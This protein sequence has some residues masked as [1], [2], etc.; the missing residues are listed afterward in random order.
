M[1]SAHE[2]QPR[3]PADLQNAARFTNALSP[4]VIRQEMHTGRFVDLVGGLSLALLLAAV[5]FSGPPSMAKGISTSLLGLYII[6]IGVLNLISY[7]FIEE[8]YILKFLRW[9][10]E[11]FS[12]PKGRGMA[13]FYAALAFL[14]GFYGL[15]VGIGIISP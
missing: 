13:F 2:A 15:F 7:F 6:E 8:S 4:V 14:L 1:V 5:I 9:K 11:N 3:A 10:C 12:H